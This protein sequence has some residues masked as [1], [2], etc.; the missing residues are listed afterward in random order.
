V[1]I[2]VHAHYYPQEYVQRIG[3]TDLPLPSAL[4]GAQTIGER[5]ELL[6]SA[7]IDAQVL[8]VSQAQPYLPDEPA[9]ADSARLV[10]DLYVQL[11]EAHPGRFYAF[12][13]LPLPHID[14]ALAELDRTAG[15]PLVVGIALGCSVAGRQLD[16][17][18]FEPLYAELDRRESRVFLHPLGLDSN[19]LLAGHRLAW[20]VG[21]PFEDTVAALRLIL[22]GVTSCY[23]GIRFIVPHLGGTIPFLL[24]RLARQQSQDIAGALRSM[25]FD[26]VSGSADALGSAC[27]AYGADR[28]MFGTDYPYCSEPQFR[29]HLSYLDEAGLD[30]AAL[31]Q[32]RGERAAA[33][34]GLTV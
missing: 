14:A 4:L 2:D 11:C 7:G 18:L 1:I 30:G 6:D 22:S 26:T 17:P 20:L 23:P 34:L 31:D 29:R 5:L 24:A 33:V 3:R 9:A 32:I 8:S 12:A 27:H 16:D 19:P 15:S 21:A 25:Y 13:A 28:L 10:N